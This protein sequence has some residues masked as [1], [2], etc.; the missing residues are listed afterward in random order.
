[1]NAPLTVC[2]A[3]C[4]TAGALTFAGCSSETSAGA[5]PSEL[6]FSV[7]P[8]FHKTETDAN[9][10]QLARVL[11][12]KLGMP[13]R[14]V[15]A[16]SYPGAVD[17]LLSNKVDFVWLGGKTTCDA[18]DAGD[19][20]VHV[21]ATRDIDL[22]FK[23]YFIANARS[24]AAGKVGPMQ[25]LAE[26]GAKTKDLVFTFGD[27]SS[28]SGH[29]MPRYFLMQAGID[30]NADFASMGYQLAGG[31]GAT[32]AA[33]ASGAADLGALNY[34]HYDGAEP[35]T[36]AAAPIVWT[37]PEY[38]DYA[39]VGHDR[40]GGD[41]L[42]RITA[43]FTGLDPSRPEDAAILAT[44]SVKQRFLPAQ[45]SQWDSIRKVRDSLPKN[46]WDR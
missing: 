35:T 4:L 42:A 26:L 39:W 21:L 30:P 36:R 40:V 5:A 13:V 20:H 45:D 1:M 22:A 15:A 38:V 2:L 12:A 33:V 25:D 44:W 19:G 3:V 46:F 29:L 9:A 43:A 11:T 14:Y 8:D 31:H 24:I 17:N 7:L 32:L 6:R 18:I 34:G 41:V 23:S 37:S 27:R 28:T 16:N 10:E